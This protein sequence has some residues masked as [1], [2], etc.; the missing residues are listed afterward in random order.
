M[1]LTLG[2]IFALIFLLI[3]LSW[4]WPPDSPWAP[5]WRTNKKTADA[6]C[7]LANI[8]REDVV[9]DLGCGDG[10]VLIAAADKFGIKGVGIEIDI[11][12]F[13]IASIRVGQHGLSDYLNIRRA[14]FFKQDI[15]P[16][17]VVIVYL[18]PAT[19]KKLLP[20]FKKDL[21][22]GTRIISYRYDIEGLKA[23]KVDLLNDLRLYVI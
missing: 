23:K 17:S 11:L 15:S 9:Y 21:K 13:F 18:V 22:R 1:V 16:A 20:K 12:R 10:E 5:W 8:K 3:I 4:I 6:I 7:K 2:L 14:N 19:L